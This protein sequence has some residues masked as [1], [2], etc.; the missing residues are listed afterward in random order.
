MLSG[1]FTLLWT[2]VIYILL[3]M[4]LPGDS[5]ALLGQ[6]DLLVHLGLFLFLG[7]LGLLALKPQRSPVK[8]CFW[9]IYMVFVALSSELGQHFFPTRTVANADIVANLLGLLAAIII[10]KLERDHFSRLVGITAGTFLMLGVGGGATIIARILTTSRIAL[11][12][13]LLFYGGIAPWLAGFGLLF[14]KESDNT[15]KTLSVLGVIS[16]LLV[17]NSRA[18]PLFLLAGGLLLFILGLTLGSQNKII[19]IIQRHLGVPGIIS[20]YLLGVL[21]A[22]LARNNCGILII[23]TYFFILFSYCLQ[24][25]FNYLRTVIPEQVSPE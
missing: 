25:K 23:H 10:W 18:H 1:I 3:W 11:A 16:L 7:G 22:A 2:A 5:P 4:P 17:I 19:K 8:W 6:M 9:A 20:W 13:N 14:K 15:W 21:P 12:E 24:K